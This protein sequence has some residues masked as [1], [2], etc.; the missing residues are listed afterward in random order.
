MKKTLLSGVILLALLTIGCQGH[1]HTYELVVTKAADWHTFI[2][3]KDFDETGLEVALRCTQCGQSEVVAYSLENSTALTL[4][5]TAVLIKYDDYQLSYPIV[6]K[7]KY[8]LAC[9]G[10]SLTKGHNWPNQSY[11]T[12]LSQSVS[13]DYQVGN[14]GENG[15]SITGYGGSWNDPNKSYIKQTFY[16]NSLAF[17]PDIIAMMLGTNDATGWANAEATFLSEY[18]VLLDAYLAV[19]PDVKIIMMVSP[20]T[21]YPN[22]FSIPNDTIRDYVNPIQRDLA[23]E[24]G[25]EILDLREE[26]EAT[27]NYASLYL[28]P[29]GDN[30]HFTEAGSQYVAQRVWELASE[31]R[32]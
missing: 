20:P 9:V 10:D 13:S 23:D 1:E 26:F 21:V 30:V 12:Y 8:H 22:N 27:A 19:L 24:Y 7:E 14:Y 18:R 31:L 2:Q 32:F 11:P 28:R 6:V 3:G 16:T 17:A 25:L 4:D 29:N 5:Q 15:I